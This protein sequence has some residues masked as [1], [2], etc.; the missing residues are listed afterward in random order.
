MLS[1]MVVSRDSC[2]PNCVPAC[3]S[4]QDG[5]YAIREV[6]PHLTSCLSVYV[7]AVA[8]VVV[9]VVVVLTLFV[10]VVVALLLCSYFCVVAFQIAYLNSANSACSYG[11][12]GSIVK[13]HHL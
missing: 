10:V 13:I 1:V 8:D 12:G 2:V 7:V 9:T 4:V 3:R 11:K 5:L 6:H